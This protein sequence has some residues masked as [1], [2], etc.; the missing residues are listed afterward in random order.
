MF[1]APIFFSIDPTFRDF[2]ALTTCVSTIFQK[3][4]LDHHRLLCDRS[5]IG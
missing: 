3:N 4:R 2:L 5:P 1:G